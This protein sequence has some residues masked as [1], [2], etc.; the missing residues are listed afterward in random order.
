MKAYLKLIDTRTHGPRYDVTPLFADRKA[1]RLLVKDLSAPFRESR[2]DG[3]AC[4]DALGFILGT[5][6]A[7]ELGTRIVPMRKNGKLPVPTDRTMFRDYTG[8]RK[9]LELRKRSIRPGE[10]LLVVDEWIETG[11]QVKAAIRL[12]QK[13]R[14]EVIGIASV[15]MDNN[16]STD[17]IR[18]RHR[19]HTVWEE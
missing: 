2:I 8:T 17:L 10:R 18:R 3:V 5:A 15:S 4:I 9:G 13:Q 1:F 12:I 6:I 11:A 14:G 19:V 16:R 7:L